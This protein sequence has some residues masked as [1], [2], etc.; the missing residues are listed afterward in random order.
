VVL[1]E[2]F[3]LFAAAKELTPYDE[4]GERSRVWHCLRT[5]RRD[6]T[7]IGVWH[8]P[9]TK[10]GTI[11]GTQTCGSVWGCPVCAAKIAERRCQEVAAGI[12][13]HRAA[14]GVVLAVA[15]T[16]RHERGDELADILRRFLAALRAMQSGAPWVRFR[17]DWG[18]N[19]VIRSIECTWGLV[20]G[21]HPHAHFLFFIDPPRTL[22]RM[23]GELIPVADWS[24]DVSGFHDAIYDRWQMVA[25]RHGFTMSDEYGVKVQTTATFDAVVVAEYVA[26]HGHE[27]ERRRWSAAH[28]VTKG[29]VKRGKPGRLTPWDFLRR[30]VAAQTLDERSAWAARWREYLAAFRGMAQLR[31][32]RKLRERLGLEVE[33]SDA[34]VAAEQAEDGVLLALLYLDQWRAVWQA[35]KVAD[36][37]DAAGT[38]DKAAVW[39][40]V[41]VAVGQLQISP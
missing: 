5:P 37:L 22:D 11:S 12:A 27:P 7:T 41:A 39:A 33:R 20:N 24:P 26:K 18:V 13:A 34:E 23:T 10:S 21:Y 30:F 3:T 35:G 17:K 25:E 9:R 15:L 1:A 19:G 36:L 4:H 16:F 14:G 31:W 40:V 38:G 2:R 29:H 28:E 8:Q 6:V 32:S